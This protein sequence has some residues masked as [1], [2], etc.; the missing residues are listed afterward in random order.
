M[1]LPLLDE[2]QQGVALLPTDHVVIYLKLLL[3][4]AQAL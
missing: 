2:F 1:Q 3:G 4:L